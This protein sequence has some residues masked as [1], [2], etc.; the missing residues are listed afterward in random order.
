[1]A[2]LVLNRNTQ[3]TIVTIVDAIAY[4]ADKLLES[5]T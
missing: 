2:M 4:T 3:V 1:M 5:I